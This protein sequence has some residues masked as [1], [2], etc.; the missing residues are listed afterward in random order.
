MNFI[1]NKKDFTFSNIY[2]SQTEVQ[3]N[4]KEISYINLILQKNSKNL[5]SIRKINNRNLNS[6]FRAV[7][8]KHLENFIL[9]APNLLQEIESILNNLE[10]GKLSFFDP[11]IKWTEK[12]FDILSNEKKHILLAYYLFDL[13]KKVIIFFQV[14]ILFF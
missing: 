11:T 10:M 8:W 9:A 13:Y 12:S 1:K 3:E 4:D 2:E 6:I 14:I 5:K 7:A